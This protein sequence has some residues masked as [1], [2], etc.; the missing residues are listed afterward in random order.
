MGYVKFTEA[1][2]EISK[3]YE[4]GSYEDF[5]DWGNKLTGVLVSADHV[6]LDGDIWVKNTG[7]KPNL[8]N[9]SLVEVEFRNG[10]TSEG[11]VMTWAWYHTLDEDDIMRYRAVSK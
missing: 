10:E 8:P 7:V 6:I 3:T 4:F 1:L 11:A 2:G 5:K 9:E